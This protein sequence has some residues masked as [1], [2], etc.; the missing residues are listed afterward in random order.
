MVETQSS[1]MRETLHDSPPLEPPPLESEEKEEMEGWDEGA[2]EMEDRRRRFFL[3]RRLVLPPS[4][5]V[6]VP[7]SVP[8]PVASAVEV[9]VVVLFRLERLRK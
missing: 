9:V 2:E 1:V 6:P 8:V 5:P 3:D 7:E 4:V